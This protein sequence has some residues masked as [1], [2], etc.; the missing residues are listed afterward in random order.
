MPRVLIDTYGCTLNHADSDIMAGLLSKEGYYVESAGH[1]AK[2]EH[3]YVIV[4]TCT[5]KNPTETKI[6]Q[7]LR[8]LSKTNSKI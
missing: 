8:D 3:D 1:S 5:V 2:A 7:R 4:N 6:L